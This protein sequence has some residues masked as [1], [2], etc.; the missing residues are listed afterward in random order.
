MSAT[1]QALM[2][3]DMFRAL[4]EF[5]DEQDEAGKALVVEV[6]EKLWDA[7]LSSGPDFNTDEMDADEALVDLELARFGADE[8]GDDALLSR[9][10]DEW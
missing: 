9:G 7:M 4:H 8:Y 6:A 1:T 5:W 2:A 10:D 3:G